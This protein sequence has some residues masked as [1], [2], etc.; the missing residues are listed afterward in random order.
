M[1]CILTLAPQPGYAGHPKVEKYT[2]A[3][4]AEKINLGL[5]QLEQEM[6]LQPISLTK[7]AASRAYGTQGDGVKLD[8]LMRYIDADVEAQLVQAGAEIRHV[9]MAHRRVSVVVDYPSVIYALAQLP[10]VET[11]SPEYGAVVHTGSVDG[12]ASEAMMADIAR[13][14]TSLD[15]SGQTVAGS[16]SSALER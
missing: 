4:E 11:I 6:R 2:Q 7:A 9:S 8:I 10:A 16:Y 14:A 3:S 13:L 1:M 5:L 15:G 12:R